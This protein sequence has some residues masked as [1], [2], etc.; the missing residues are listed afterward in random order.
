MHLY[1]K[2]LF[3]E[4]KTLDC[5]L[6]I[7]YSLK[8]CHNVFAFVD[9]TTLGTFLRFWLI[10]L[11]VWTFLPLILIYR[12]GVIL[13]TVFIL[14]LWLPDLQKGITLCTING[15]VHNLSFIVLSLLY[16]RGQLF[17]MYISSLVISYSFHMEGGNFV[18]H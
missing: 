16:G 18:H 9:L 10:K 6:H 14:F 17:R 1:Y 2:N 13:C 12:K 3:R 15:D 5:L 11:S 8:F 4:E 7:L